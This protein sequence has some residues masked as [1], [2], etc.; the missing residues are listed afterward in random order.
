MFRNG[1]YFLSFLKWFI[2]SKHGVIFVT[3]THVNCDSELIDG[4]KKGGIS[5]ATSKLV[6]TIEAGCHIPIL[7]RYS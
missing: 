7:A 5:W 3:L 2:P 1:I 6:I 4:T